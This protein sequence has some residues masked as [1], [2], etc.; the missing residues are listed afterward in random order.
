MKTPEPCRC[1]GCSASVA[2][3]VGATLAE[4]AAHADHLR[5]LAAIGALPDPAFQPYP[6]PINVAASPHF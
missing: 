1:S 6:Q 5:K 2:P 4:H 3:A